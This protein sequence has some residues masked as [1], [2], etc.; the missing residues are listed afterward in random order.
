MSD[1]PGDY[2]HRY[3]EVIKSEKDET[4]SERITEEQAKEALEMAWPGVEVAARRWPDDA[5]AMAIVRVFLFARQTLGDRESRSEDVQLVGAYIGTLTEELMKR[6]SHGP[7]TVARREA[8]LAALSR[9]ESSAATNAPDTIESLAKAQGVKPVDDVA[10]LKVEG[11]EDFEVPEVAPCL[12]EEA[13]RWLEAAQGTGSINISKKTLRALL[14]RA[15]RCDCGERIEKAK[16]MS[17]EMIDFF[18]DGSPWEADVTSRGL[19]L[20]AILEG[21]EGSES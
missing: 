1:K 8:A 5:D 11:A 10:K 18:D 9:L 4:M 3:I 21:R 12:S 17:Q 6:G 13:E 2:W 19:D 20:K 14:S 7:I 15:G 16:K